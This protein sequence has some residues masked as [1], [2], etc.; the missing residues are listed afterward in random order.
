MGLVSLTSMSVFSFVANRSLDYIIK[1]VRFNAIQATGA[2]RGGK[3]M[4]TLLLEP[5][6]F[7]STPCPGCFNPGK[8]T[9]CLLYRRLGGTRMGA[10]NSVLL[11]FVPRTLQPVT[12]LYTNDAIPNSNYYVKQLLE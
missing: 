8:Q 7:V 11:G 10:E 3:G 1:E 5:R 12:S 9:R 6:G 4:P 2:L